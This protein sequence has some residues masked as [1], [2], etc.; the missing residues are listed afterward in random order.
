MLDRIRHRLWLPLALSLLVLGCAVDKDPVAPAPID[1][2]RLSLLALGDSYTV[3]HSLP[4]A[5]S[6]PVQLADSLA[7]TGDTLDVAQ[8]IAETGWTTRDLLDAARDSLPTEGNY[9]AVTVMIGVNNQFQGGDP[10]V[11][12]AEIDTLLELAVALVGGDPNRVLGFSIPDYGQTPI[13][14]LYGAERIAGEIDTFNA[15]LAEHL[16][17]FGIAYLD[18]TTM[19]RQVVQEPDLVSRDGLHYSQEMYRRWVAMM[20][21]SVVECLEMAAVAGP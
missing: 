20:L 4:T 15:I 14:S 19:S 11:F 3:G 7:A 5:F 2:V 21:P 18:V 9:G 16:H 8:V 12:A 1:P 6:W 13:G 10:A 17:T